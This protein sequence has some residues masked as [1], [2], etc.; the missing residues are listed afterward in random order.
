M[1]ETVEKPN[2]RSVAEKIVRV[3]TG[4]RPGEVVQLGGGVHN[5]DLLAALAAAVRRAGAFPEL[6]VTSDELQWET[7]TE[8]PIEHLRT[9]PPHRLRWL[10]DI[11]VMIVTD[12]IA[13]PAKAADV[14][15]ER[16]LAAHAA[17]EAVE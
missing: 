6:N 5:F 4:V 1:A 14:P 8:T 13:D 3:C 10:E 2:F 17:A 11:D 12:A 7:M 15:E 9:V 16:R